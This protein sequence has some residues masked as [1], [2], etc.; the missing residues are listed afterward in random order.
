MDCTV[1]NKLRSRIG[2]S[3]VVLRI[4]NIQRAAGRKDEVIGTIFQF[5]R[6]LSRTIYS[7][8]I[9]KDLI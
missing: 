7:K 8:S 2:I 6:I 3:E 1:G 5:A 4:R 9:R